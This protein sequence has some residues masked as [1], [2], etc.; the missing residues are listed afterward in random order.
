MER[1]KVLPQTEDEFITGVAKDC[2][3]NL[4]DEDKQYLCDNPHRTDYHFGYAL[5]IRNHYIHNK[6]FSD[7]DFFVEPDHLSGQI[8]ERIF[9]FLLPDEYFY[10]DP[11]VQQMFG[12]KGFIRLRKAYRLKHGAYPVN[13]EM[14]Y[15]S[16]APKSTS[17]LDA[18]NLKEI[19][20]LPGSFDFKADLENSKID[21]TKR[22][23][24]IDELIRELA[25]IIWATD[26]L[27]EFA[28]SC[29]IRQDALLPE[30][31]KI[32]ALFFND[33]EYIPITSVLI[34]YSDRIGFEKYKDIRDD[35]CSVLKEQPR[36]MKKFD[37]RFF[38]DPAIAKV[39]LKYG[40]AM[41]FLPEYQND[42]EMVRY[43]LS[44]DGSAIRFVNSR[45]IQDRDWVRLAIQHSA[46]DIIMHYDC[47]APYRQDKEL[48]YLA[49]SL[50]RWNFAYVDPSF[51][52]DYELAK[53]VLA[54]PGTLMNI[55]ELLSDRLKDNLSLALLDAQ[56][57]FPN[58][59]DYSERLRDNEEVA[60][61]LIKKHGS[62]SW[63]LGDMS[64]RIKQKYNYKQEWNRRGK[65]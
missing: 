55:F 23:E 57:E 6:D 47:M 26:E 21:Y 46:K 12:H 36:L 50:H 63:L 39:V 40:F 4:K 32:K 51:H 22:S 34:P 20:N 8:M 1:E 25:D 5:Y 52:D 45:Y 17:V 24:L 64:E 16:Q 37:Q 43:A 9:S 2:I 65:S 11:F 59:K 14:R 54:P 33:S 31:E 19:R 18:L 62:A 3:S 27:L 35:F 48:V 28:E 49:C 7:V 53:I 60:D 56:G 61:M 10:K 58:V 29:D 30:I 42:D 38:H 13:L 41:E 15:Y 44:Q